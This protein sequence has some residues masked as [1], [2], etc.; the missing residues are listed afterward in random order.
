MKSCS[1]ARQITESAG[2]KREAEDCWT[3]FATIPIRKAKKAAR[4]S[5][6][7]FE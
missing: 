4:K 1:S 7:Y 2:V 3:C 5:H 6:Y